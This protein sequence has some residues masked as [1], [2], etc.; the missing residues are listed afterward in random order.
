M[1]SQTLRALLRRARW[2]LAVAAL[3]AG[4]AACGVASSGSGSQ[5]SSTSG[6]SLPTSASSAAAQA[7]APAA[8]ANAEITS[9]GYKV[10]P[11]VPEFGKGAVGVNLTATYRYMGALIVT[12]AQDAQAAV[13]YYNKHPQTGVT[14]TVVTTTSGVALLVVKAESLKDAKAAADALSKDLRA[15][16]KSST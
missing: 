2:I 4:V 6:N 12:N 11:H 8:A 7:M 9:A 15:T 5:G 3:V 16:A 1:S 14:V 13:A 10:V